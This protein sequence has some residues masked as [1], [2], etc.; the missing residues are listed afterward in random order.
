MITVPVDRSMTRPSP[1]SH[2]EPPARLRI[3]ESSL[4]TVSRPEHAAYTFT[5]SVIAIITFLPLAVLG[6]AQLAPGAEPVSSWTLP[7]LL[8]SCALL[9]AGL[10]WMVSAST[11]TVRA[12][13]EDGVAVR[14]WRV[15]RTEIPWQAIESVRTGP[16][17]GTMEVGP[18]WYGPGRIGYTGGSTSVVIRIHP[19]YRQAARQGSIG[20]DTVRRL[21]AE[22]VVSVPEPEA[23]ASKLTALRARALDAA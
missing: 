12:T 20:G 14:T 16:T 9:G 1:A 13:V 11:I 3:C 17:G 18:R 6:V 15:V 4:E 21:A 7:T 23:V 19:L 22:Y 2:P 10:W 5:L 8:V